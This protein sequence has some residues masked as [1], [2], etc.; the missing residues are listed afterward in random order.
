MAKAQMSKEDIAKAMKNARKEYKKM[1]ENNT[2]FA[3]IKKGTKT[4]VILI[5]KQRGFADS[6]R[7]YDDEGRGYKLSFYNRDVPMYLVKDLK[8]VM[9]KPKFIKDAY[10]E[11]RV[12]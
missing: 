8:K 9:L 4:D 3:G 7:V 2:W 11:N 5:N 10:K 12:D 6:P 1:Y